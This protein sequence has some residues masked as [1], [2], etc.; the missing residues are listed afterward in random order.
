MPEITIVYIT[1]PAGKDLGGGISVVGLTN[2]VKEVP[3]FVTAY[4][5]L[6]TPGR[7]GWMTRMPPFL[8]RCGDHAQLVQAIAQ[9]TH[10]D[11]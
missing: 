9:R 5:D 1:I 10:G 7:M 8:I 4:F 6:K 2:Y 3:F 11:S